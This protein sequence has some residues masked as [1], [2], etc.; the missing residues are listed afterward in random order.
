MDEEAEAERIRLL[1]ERIQ[2]FDKHQN[3]GNGAANGGAMS[4]DSSDSDSSGSDSD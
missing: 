4:S 3:G 1:E 2:L